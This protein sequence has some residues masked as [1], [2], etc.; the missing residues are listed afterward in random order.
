MLT[1]IGISSTR[2]CQ[3]DI[4]ERQRDKVITDHE[5][6]NAN[7]RCSR[8]LYQ[9]LVSEKLVPVSGTYDM[10]S[11]IDFFLVPDSAIG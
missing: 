3:R 10:Q 8:N 7:D 4:R 5:Q 2:Y 11:F 6:S 9:K 1:C